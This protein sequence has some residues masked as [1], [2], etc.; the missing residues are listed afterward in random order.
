MICF[1]LILKTSKVMF[2]LFPDLLR[3]ALRCD[4]AAIATADL[5][6]RESATDLF[7]SRPEPRF[8]AAGP[9]SAPLAPS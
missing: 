3:H 9:T 7:F 1:R 8:F 2:V 5:I 4:L 6:A